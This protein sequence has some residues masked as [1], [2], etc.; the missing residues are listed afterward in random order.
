MHG[1]PTRDDPREFSSQRKYLTGTIQ[2]LVFYSEANNQ[3]LVRVP[4]GFGSA[5]VL[6]RC[7]L[8]KRP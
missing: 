5:G 1:K 3:I 4:A 8:V 2:G 7:S 6:R